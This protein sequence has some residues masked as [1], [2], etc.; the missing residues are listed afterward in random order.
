MNIRI[1]LAAMPPASAA[2]PDQFSACIKDD[3]ARW[4][5]VVKDANIKVE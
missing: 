1:L 2:T 3:F 4:T 5:Q